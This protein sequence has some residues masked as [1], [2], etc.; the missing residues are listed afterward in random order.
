MG[1]RALFLCCHSPAFQAASPK[2]SIPER[3]VDQPEMVLLSELVSPAKQ[4]RAVAKS[5]RASEKA[6]VQGAASPLPEHEVSSL[7]LIFLPPQ[8]ATRDCA[9]ALAKQ[10]KRSRRVMPG[11]DIMRWSSA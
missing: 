11:F 9:T 5:G 4:D 6:A 10:E 7:L 3:G 2:K 8:A 1:K